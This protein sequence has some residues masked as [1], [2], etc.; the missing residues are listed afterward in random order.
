MV[1]VM[2]LENWKISM[3]K[4]GW[5]EFFLETHWF[6]IVVLSWNKSTIRI[7]HFRCPCI[8]LHLVQKSHQFSNFW[9]NHFSI[10]ISFQ[11]KI[12]NSKFKNIEIIYLFCTKLHN[13]FFNN[14]IY[15]HWCR[16]STMKN[17]IQHVTQHY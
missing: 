15:C 16:T 6:A 4:G 17:T 14:W 7:F 13:F 5:L 1:N 11:F 10:F 12:P 3:Q 2:E 8:D 9:A